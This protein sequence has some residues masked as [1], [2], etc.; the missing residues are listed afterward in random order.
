MKRILAILIC[1]LTFSQISYEQTLDAK[2]L[3]GMK[4]R[5]I[6]P[7]GMSG[8]VTSIDVVQKNKSIIYVGSASGGL[9]KST[10][11]GTSFSSIFNH[12]KTASIGSISIYQKNPNIIYIGTGE[13]NPRNSQAFGYGM[14]KS[15]DGGATWKHLG[16]EK[17][18][19]IHRVIVHPDNPD[20]VWVGAIGPAYGPNQD[21]GVYKSKDGG[22][23][24]T[25]ILYVNETTG[26]ADMIIDPSNPN[27]LFVAMWD[28]YRK[29]WTFNS[30]GKGS[31]LY[32]TQ[33]GGENWTKLGAQ[34]GLPMGILG[35]MGLSFAPS[36]PNVVY[37]NIET[38]KENALYRSNNGGQKWVKTTNKG[39]SDRPFYYSDIEVSPKNENLVYHIATTLSKSEDG[40]RNFKPMLNFF[41]GVHS[42]H[43]AFWINPEDPN[44]ILDGNDG[45]LYVSHDGGKTWRFH[46][47]LPLGQ[48]YHINVDNDEPYNVYGGMQDNGSWCGPAYK[49][50][51]LENIYNKDFKSVGFG[52]GFDV[53]PDPDNSRF[54]YS[55]FQGGEYQRY[56]RKTG[57]VKNIKPRLAD[58]T[59]LRFNWNSAMA[60]DY[61]TP[62]V[63]YVGSQ[64]VHKTTTQGSSWE[65]ISPDLT[66]NDTAKQ[67]QHLSGGLTIDNSTAENHTS[68]TVIEPSSLEKDLLWVGTDDGI[69]H[70]SKDGGENWTNLSANIPQVPKNTWITQI[71]HSTYNKGEAFIVFDDHR[72]NNWEP[73]V[74]KTTNYGKKWTRIVDPKQV[75]GYALSFVQDPIS[76]N[77]LFLGTEFGLYVSIDAGK[78]WTKWGNDFP[79]TS[80]MD[81]VIHPREHDLV[82]GTF[83]RSIWILDDIRPLRAIAKH[84]E[85]LKTP[86]A[87]FPIPVATLEVIGFPEFFRG[88]NG[89]FKGANRPLGMRISYFSNEN[90]PKDSLT[91]IVRDQNKQI[92][93]TKNIS[94]K[95]G[96]NRFTWDLKKKRAFLPGPPDM[97][98]NFLLTGVDVLPGNYEITLKTTKDSVVQN[99]KVLVDKDMPFSL[100]E[101]EQSF[102]EKE[103][104]L[105]TANGIMKSYKLVEGIEK[106]LKKVAAICQQDKHLS[107]QLKALQQ[108]CMALKLKFVPKPQK[109]LLTGTPDLRSQFLEMSSYYFNS[110]TG[111]DENG[112]RALGTINN[113]LAMIDKEIEQFKNEEVATFKK[114]LENATLKLWD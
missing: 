58:N 30:G 73:Y 64:F 5:N 53:L 105:A 61:H 87:L 99:A 13:G 54:G 68:I 112:K 27:K 88:A 101:L 65:I 82:V 52:D 79:T 75:W 106:R 32:S 70:I 33:D 111:V 103:K 72:R 113:Q 92:V 94:A 44:H 86:I 55:M 100:T 91:L 107:K 24:W 8:R 62:S 10:N 9:W 74:Y 97:M 1:I 57:L 49:I 85:Q 25:K 90:L 67:Q 95:K 18:T 28:Y 63:I 34:N 109:G 6:G 23:S 76:P 36:N 16:L 14:Y 43:H 29:P 22:K 78:N 50:G 15:L 84:K 93:S 66:T 31:A 42:D 11:A 108:K 37:A 60:R 2:L 96:I 19:N 20:I 98:S 51:F 77:L 89:I 110:M 21:R 114:E 59:K 80:A 41:D 56:D 40:G 104:Y 47:N 83:G 35:R 4:F 81:M 38:K 12:Q 17:T 71:K 46:N 69:L 7:A 26:V 48:F 39:V 102:K 3:H 45:G